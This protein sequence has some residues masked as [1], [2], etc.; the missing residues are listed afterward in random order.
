LSA[1]YSF[2]ANQVYSSKNPFKQTDALTGKIGVCWS[3]KLS[4]NDENTSLKN[5]RRIFR[6]V[7]IV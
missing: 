1:A 5:L 7:K 6:G 2:L 3:K 4:T